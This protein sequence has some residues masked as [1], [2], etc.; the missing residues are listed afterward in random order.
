M[1]RVQ[2]PPWIWAIGAI[3]AVQFGSAWSVGLID[4]IGAG[5]T[6]WLRLTI[7]ALIFL[8]ISR[9]PFRKIDRKDIPIL[10]GLGITTGVMTVAF[11][12]AIELIP[13]GTSVAIEFL[14]PLT[15]AGLGSRNK[16]MLIWPL[17][18]F[19]G[20]VL[21]TEPWHGEIN[22][23]GVGFA[24]LSGVMWGT[25]IVLT[26]KVGD[27]FEGIS[28]LTITIPIAAIV[29]AFVGV[30]QAWGKIDLMILLIALGLALLAPVAVFGLEMMALKRMTHTA[31]GT[32][33]AVEPAVALVLGLIIL[34]QQ[35]NAIQVVGIVLVVIA[36][37]MA[38][39][40]GTRD[41][42]VQRA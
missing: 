21:L 12:A 39:K 34:Q 11:L 6:A 5:G 14:G 31:F 37:V 9:P 19:I 25:Y 28:G 40:E 35:P 7:G 41:L 22:L 27:R 36:G 42:D 20:V 18:A 13:L 33:M 30:P 4:L 38:Q 23:V 16:K 8:I 17:I 24:A 29:A 32:L 3:L 15:V 1:K 10:L 26:Q 2:S